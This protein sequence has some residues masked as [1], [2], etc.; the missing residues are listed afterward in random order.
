MSSIDRERLLE[1]FLRYVRIHTTAVEDAGVYPSSPGQLTLGAMLAAELQGMG[2]AA[3]EQTE[4]GIVYGTLPA[5][6]DGAPTIAL[7][8]HVDTS[9][10]TSGEN[11][12]PQVIRDYAGGDIPLPADPAKIIRERENPELHDLLGATLITTDGTTLL[13]GDD[14]AGVAVIME[15][16]QTLLANPDAPHGKIQVVFTC[17]EEIGHGV[18]HVDLKRLDAAACYTLD[19]AGANDIDAE[20]FSADLAIVRFRGVNIHPSIAKDKMINALRVAGAFLSKLPRHLSPEA[21]SEREGFIHPYVVRG[22]VAEVELKVL[23]RSFDTQQLA[24][25]ADL[26]RETAEDVRS[27]FGGSQIEIE[28]REQYRN[29]AEG[30]DREPRAV[31]YA[32]RAHEKLGRRPR[33]AVVRGGTDGS[34]FTELGL[35]TPNLSTGQHNPHSPLEWACLDEMEQAVELLIALAGEWAADA[36]A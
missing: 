36:G 6:V 30:L 17:D 29:M 3:V 13:G 10:E 5:N 7:N 24:E 4:H 14:K 18:D 27:E 34:R 11:V 16:V 33:L 1:R 35:P 32:V 9:P 19:G 20:T 2:L 22:G 28:V 12:R 21:T 15:A 25:Y 8:A 23:L 31:A 26:L